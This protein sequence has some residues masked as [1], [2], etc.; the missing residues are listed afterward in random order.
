ME[1]YC[2]KCRA[3]RETKSPKAV[4]TKNGIPAAQSVCPICKTKMFGIG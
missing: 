2:V 4:I 3:K 1:A